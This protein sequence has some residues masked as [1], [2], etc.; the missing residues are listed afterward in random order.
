VLKGKLRTI[1]SGGGEDEPG[2]AE[3]LFFD[4]SSDTCEWFHRIGGKIKLFDSAKRRMSVLH[5]SIQGGGLSG[6]TSHGGYFDSDRLR[7]IPHGLKPYR[8]ESLLVLGWKTR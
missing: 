7:G 3:P 8:Q 1:S 6:A 2:S 5:V 4:C